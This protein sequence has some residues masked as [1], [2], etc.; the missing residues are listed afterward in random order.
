MNQPAPTVEGRGTSSNDPEVGSV[1]GLLLL[2]ALL[3]A[4]PAGAQKDF[5]WPEFTK[6]IQV[7]GNVRGEEL[8]QIMRAWSKS[9]GVRC[10]HCHVGEEGQP[11]ST[12]EFASDD[13]PNKLVAREMVRMMES[14]NETLTEVQQPLEEKA[15]VGCVNCHMGQPEPEHPR[16]LF[17]KID[18]ERKQGG[19]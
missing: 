4:S 8:G 18:E 13:K 3:V 17:E 15:T 11:L 2:L 19:R 7:L 6:N 5:E 10:T 1:R 9:L 16:A 14:I 12:F